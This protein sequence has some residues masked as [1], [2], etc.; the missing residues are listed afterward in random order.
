MS[1][2]YEL[3]GIAKDVG[4][5]RICGATPALA[6]TL[7]QQQGMLVALKFR[8]LPGPFCRDCGIALFRQLTNRTLLLGWWGIPA[9]FVNFATIVGNLLVRRRLRRLPAPQLD[10]AGGRMP[11]DPGLP[12]LARA[13]AW[14]GAAVVAAALVAGYAAVSGPRADLRVD[15]CIRR[16]DGGKVAVVACGKP[17]DGAVTRQ[18]SQRR[19]C[20][21]GTDGVIEDDQHP[22]RI[23]CVDTDR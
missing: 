21:A 19:D 6:A 14:V 12:L 13:G 17:H 16:L 7:R 1:T 3:L 9:L 5:C 4:P 8:R 20:P 10:L 15:G 11:L 23:F 22:A 18:V 2:Y